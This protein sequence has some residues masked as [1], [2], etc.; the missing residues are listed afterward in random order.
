MTSLHRIRWAAVGTAALAVLFLSILARQDATLQ[1]SLV[2][3]SILKPVNPRAVVYERTTL[4]SGDL[5]T[6]QLTADR[7]PYLLAG[8][9]RIP[10]GARVDAQPGTIVAAAEGAQLRVEGA[11]SA[12]RAAFMSNHLHPPPSFLAWP[13]DG[14]R[15]TS[16]TLPLDHCPRLSGTHMRTR[17]RPVRPQRVVPRQHRGDYLASGKR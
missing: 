12:D 3:F 10:P 13:H 17:R 7:G 11:L 4:L 6:Q 15:W 14:A 8:A 5:Q 2:D 16:D 1:N 9:A